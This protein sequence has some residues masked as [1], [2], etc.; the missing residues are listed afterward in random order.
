[1]LVVAMQHEGRPGEEAASH[2]PALGAVQYRL[3]PGH[4]SGIRLVGIDQQ[5]RGSV[6]GTR[7]AN[8]HRIRS[9]RQRRVRWQ[10]G[11]LTVA[12][13]AAASRG[14]GQMQQYLVE[15]IE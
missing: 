5:P 10:E 13:D 7:W 11:G 1:M 3:I 4:R 8:G 9:D 15:A 2:V 14:A 6:G 12:R